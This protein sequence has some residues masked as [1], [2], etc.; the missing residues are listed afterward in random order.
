MRLWWCGGW[1]VCADNSQ[2]GTDCARVAVPSCLFGWEVPQELRQLCF[3]GMGVRRCM[4]SSFHGSKDRS[5]VAAS[6]CRLAQV[7]LAQGR[8]DLDSGEPSAGQ[9]RIKRK[10]WWLLNTTRQAVPGTN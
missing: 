6:L 4:T 7:C 10:M 8:F 1:L 2:H 5:P 9:N 3:D